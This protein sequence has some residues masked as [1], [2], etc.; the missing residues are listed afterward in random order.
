MALDARVGAI[1]ERIRARGSRVARHATTGRLDVSVD[2]T[3]WSTRQAAST[4]LSPSG[5]GAGREPFATIHNSV[6]SAEEGASA[7]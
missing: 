2:P 6:G 4:D 7:S 3:E 5:R 1:T